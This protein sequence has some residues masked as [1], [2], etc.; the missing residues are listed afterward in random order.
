MKRLNIAIISSTFISE[1]RGGVPTF[2][3]GRARYLSRRC[4]VT[5]FALGNQPKP[6]TGKNMVYKAVS[7]GRLRRFKSLYLYYWL[8]L[9]VK[10]SLA[11]PDFI[12]I[13]NIPVGFPCFLLPRTTYVFHG[14]ARFAR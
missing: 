12:E 10:I 7:I 5:H 9:F 8:M 1:K 13:H 3:Y 11:R 2:V 6:V 4:N 14:P